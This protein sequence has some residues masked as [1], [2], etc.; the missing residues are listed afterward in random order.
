MGKSKK[1]RDYVVESAGALSISDGEW[2]YITPNNKRAFNPNTSVETGNF[3]SD[4]LYNLKNDLS[5]KN[6]VAGQH[7]KEVQRLKKILEREYKN[8]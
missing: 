8:L 5:E 6:N 1:G 2:K 7:P 4:Q 3:P